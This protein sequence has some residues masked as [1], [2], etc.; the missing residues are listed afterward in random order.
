VTPISIP[1]FGLNSNYLEEADVIHI[2]ATYNFISMKQIQILSN[3][4]KPVFVTMHDQRIMTGG[5]HYSGGCLQFQDSCQTCPQV[6]AVFQKL[7]QKSFSLENQ[8]IGEKS[9]VH[10]I[11]PS[12][13]LKDLALSSKLL[14][15]KSISVVRNPIPNVYFDE[16]EP[17]TRHKKLRIGF[18]SVDLNSPYKGVSILVKAIN[19]YK[20][21]N[22]GARI[23]LY[24]LGK[25][26]VSGLNTDVVVIQREISLDAE[27]SRA[28]RQFEILVVPSTQD[29][30]PSVI[31]EALACGLTVIGSNVGGIPELLTDFEMP[32]FENGDWE[33]LAKLLGTFSP[34]GSRTQIQEKARNLLGMSQLAEEFRS[35]YVSAV[36]S[37]L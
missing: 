34:I 3:G 10:F 17:I 13:W 5:C 32:V 7:V 8:Y 2:H 25:G 15:D 30:S 22:P 33:G 23:E 18:S 29:N 4:T 11:S 6:K 21:E 36:D 19:K 14:R 16:L 31:G 28:L 24:L 37:R 12:E 1:T 35:L 20:I 27:M 26:H 9:N